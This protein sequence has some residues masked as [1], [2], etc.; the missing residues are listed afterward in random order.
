M[1]SS[2]SGIENYKNIV[3]ARLGSNLKLAAVVAQR[4]STIY[5]TKRSWVQN[6]PSAGLFFLLFYILSVVRPSRRSLTEVQHYGFFNLRICFAMKLEAKP[7]RF[8][9]EDQWQRLLVRSS[10]PGIEHY[11]KFVEANY[12]K[13]QWLRL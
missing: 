12:F 5:I 8:Y 1:R 13:D 9:F 7:A 6:P 2:R 4:F 3:Q 10:R 11:M